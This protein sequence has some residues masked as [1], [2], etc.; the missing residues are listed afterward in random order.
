MLFD[1]SFKIT[2]FYEAFGKFV[3]CGFWEYFVWEIKYYELD[4]K[5]FCVG[6]LWH[7]ELGLKDGS[8]RE[9]LS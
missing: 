1:F 5:S 9:A 4:G 3:K 7:R 6:C 8:K 2:F